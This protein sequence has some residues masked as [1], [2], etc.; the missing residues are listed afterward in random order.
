MPSVGIRDY[1]VQKVTKYVVDPGFYTVP[2]PM[3]VNLKTWNSLPK[4]LQDILTDAAKEAEKKVKAQFEQLAKEERPILIKEG[5]Q[6][7]T[8]PPPE[9]EKYLRIAY[10]E[11]WKDVIE[12]A[13]QT[14]PELRKLL[15]KGKDK[16]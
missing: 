15:S 10:D 4:K 1:G 14:G 9:A 11:G 16:R 7:I 6:V 3:L 2:N 8:L 5:I 12:K 13:P